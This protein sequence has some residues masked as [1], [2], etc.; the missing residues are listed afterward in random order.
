MAVSLPLSTE[1]LHR[2]AD[3]YLAHF[4]DISRAQ[5]FNRIE[6]EYA[7][8]NTALGRL[9]YAVEMSDFVLKVLQKRPHFGALFRTRHCRDALLPK[10]GRLCGNFLITATQ[11]NKR[12]PLLTA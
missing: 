11:A 3:V 12:Y 10:C 4:P 7:D 8:L 2:L 5:W 6:R 1:K 9:N